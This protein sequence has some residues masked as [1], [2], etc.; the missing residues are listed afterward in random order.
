[1][2]FV[3]VLVVVALPASMN[4]NPWEVRSRARNGVVRS[5]NDCRRFQQEVHSTGIVILCDN[6]LTAE[7][8]DKPRVGE[9]GW[10]VG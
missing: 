3:L 9:Q 2:S 8:V 1:M 4:D 10:D 6:I 7:P 5:G